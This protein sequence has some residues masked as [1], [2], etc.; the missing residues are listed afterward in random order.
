LWR[1][2]HRNNQSTHTF[3][4]GDV[5]AT[6]KKVLRSRFKREFVVDTSLLMSD[7]TTE[8]CFFNIKFK[9]VT[10]IYGFDI[11]H[12]LK[13]IPASNILMGLRAS[14]FVTTFNRRLWCAV[15]QNIA[16]P[17]PNISGSWIKN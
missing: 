14:S 13:V 6:L 9:N 2:I 10:F 12:P 4:L 7:L 3:N 16:G 5:F 15:L 1:H 17:P 8:M 11:E